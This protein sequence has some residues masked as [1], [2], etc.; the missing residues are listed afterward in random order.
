MKKDK[1]MA[2]ELV[3]ETVQD[4]VTSVLGMTAGVTAEWAIMGSVSALALNPI[5]APIAIIGECVIGLTVMRKTKKSLNES[6]DEF[7][8]N[9]GHVIESKNK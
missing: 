5:C 8:Q 1:K 2:K 9:I 3:E 7:K 4:M 6:I